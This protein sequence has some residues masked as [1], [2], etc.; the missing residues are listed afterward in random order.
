M[1]PI[2]VW[3][4]IEARTPRQ[5][6]GQLT[7]AEAAELYEELEEFELEQRLGQDDN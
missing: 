6:Y 4:I 3:W 7:E 2:E 5:T 1:S